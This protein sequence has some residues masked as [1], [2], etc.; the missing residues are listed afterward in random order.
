MTQIVI[1]PGGFHPF[2]SGH[3]ALY[4]SA[5][6]AFPEADIYVAASD[7]RTERPFPF[8]IKQ[9]LAQVAG[10]KPS[11][12]VQVKSPF[13]SEEITAKYDPKKDVLIFVRS[14]KDKT[15]QPI[16]GGIKKDGTPAYFQ[17]YKG[18]KKLEPFGKHG[19]IAY[20]PTVEFA[21][22][23]TS[24][25]EIRSKW[26]HINT[27][28][29][30]MMVNAL[31]PSTAGNKELTKTVVKL[32]D[33]GMSLTEMILRPLPTGNSKISNVGK[34]KVVEGDVI[35]IDFSKGKKM[36]GG[37]DW[38]QLD[39]SILQSAAEWFWTEMEM[40]SFDA[41]AYKKY[42]QEL[43]DHADDIKATLALSGYD[44]DLDDDIN[45]IIL[46]YKN[47]GVYKLPTDDAYDFTGWAKD[48][49][50]M[51]EGK[52]VDMTTPMPAEFINWLKKKDPLLPIS[53]GD[54]KDRELLR[55]L[56]LQYEKETGNSLAELMEFWTNPPRGRR[57]YGKCI[58]YECNACFGDGMEFDDNYEVIQCRSCDGK[59]W[60]EPVDETFVDPDQSN[61]YWNH[62]DQK[63]GVGGQIE[64]P[65]RD[66][67]LRGR[68]QGFN[69][70]IQKI[71][72]L[73]KEGRD[74]TVHLHRK[75]FELMEEEKN[76]VIQLRGFGTKEKE[77]DKKVVDLEK[78]RQE[79]E[80]RSELQDKKRESQ[81]H[82]MH[83]IQ[84]ILFGLHEELG[85]MK[86][87][88]L[89][90]IEFVDFLE[91]IE[92][93]IHYIDAFDY[94]S[95]PFTDDD[96]NILEH[97]GKPIDS[98]E[99][100]HE[101]LIGLAMKAFAKAKSLFGTSL[102]EG[103]RNDPILADMPGGDVDTSGPKVL[104]P[105]TL[106][107]KAVGPQPAKFWNMPKIDQGDTLDYIP[108]V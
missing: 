22:G 13:R 26:P 69:E 106:K 42:G 50:T 27:R 85:D 70:S 57:K 44:I 90:P 20:L 29:K 78:I 60:V 83:V 36:T 35:N 45:N 61:Q 72:K 54:L 38:Q 67:D 100:L 4:Q 7:S 66:T 34:K 77:S 64:F 79:K 47:G 87:L 65:L 74:D 82:Y 25:T 23:I 31:Y 97:K 15:E 21:G 39:P 92:K 10:V 58:R 73:I 108:E 62:D 101:F 6:Q 53:L 55:K 98:P 19:Y 16:P 28:Q 2:H 95:F 17:P 91:E 88:G 89:M 86:Q 84:Q 49:E 41:Q 1:M 48:T 52:V 3:Y 63:I 14:E 76:N 105:K 81:K 33:A 94:D 107:T 51:N 24:A 56:R 93:L 68:R 96:G 37:P 32:I 18:A 12:F 75:L 30:G 43:K 99:I 40:T 11:E 46:T 71:R 104:R 80:K 8:Q 103:F 59:G 5:K 9:K 102:E